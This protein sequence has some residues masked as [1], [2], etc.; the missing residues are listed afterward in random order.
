MDKESK[1][2]RIS[3]LEE[4][5]KTKKRGKLRQEIKQK[6][7]KNT[8]IVTQKSSADI[9]TEFFTYIPR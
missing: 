6:F 8:D 2:P 7:S 3:E 4:T 1:D 5:E 9:R